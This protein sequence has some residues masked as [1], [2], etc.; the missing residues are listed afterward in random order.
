MFIFICI[1][2][3]ANKE[4]SWKFVLF[5]HSELTIHTIFQDLDVKIQNQLGVSKSKLYSWKAEEISHEM[6]PNS[7][8]HLKFKFFASL[9]LLVN[10]WVDITKSVNRIRQKQKQSFNIHMHKIKN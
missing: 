7:E 9:Y 8:S 2:C 3:L 6:R 10:N 4:I 5:Y 1:F